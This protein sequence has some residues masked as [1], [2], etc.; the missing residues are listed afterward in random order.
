MGAAC[1]SRVARMALALDKACAPVDVIPEPEPSERNAVDPVGL[2]YAELTPRGPGDLC[3]ADEYIRSMA[4]CRFG[5]WSV[6]LPSFAI[7][8]GDEVFVS[9]GEGSSG[10]AEALFCQYLSGDQLDLEHVT[11]RVLHWRSALCSPFACLESSP[12]LRVRAWE[13]Q[14][15][16]SCE[17]EMLGNR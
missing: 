13:L 12:L 8:G 2:M 10:T 6:E 5:A 14:L 16:C 1:G 17:Y 9:T 7:D 3:I 15:V 4:K 11:L